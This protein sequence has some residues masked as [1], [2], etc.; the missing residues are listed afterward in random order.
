[1]QP[2]G[3][4]MQGFE[5]LMQQRKFSEAEALVDRAFKLLGEPAPAAPS[6]APGDA[7]LLAYGARDTD[8]RQQIFVVRP[9]GTEKKG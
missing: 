5:P 7:S 6:P 1:M 9:D 2:V 8:G 4:L 3:E